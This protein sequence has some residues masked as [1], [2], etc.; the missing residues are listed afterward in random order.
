M[1]AQKI[2]S[3]PSHQT[4]ACSIDKKRALG[5]GISDLRLFVQVVQSGKSTSAL[6]RGFLAASR[7]GENNVGTAVTAAQRCKKSMNLR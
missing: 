1:K 6:E 3:M 2:L 5:A 4:K 7:L